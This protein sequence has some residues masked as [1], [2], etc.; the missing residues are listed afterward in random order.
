M[1]QRWLI[2]TLL[3]LLA[4]LLL[5]WL[6]LPG[7]G[8]VSG[9]VIE[10]PVAH[11]PESD[12]HG[13]GD[14]HGDDGHDDGQGDHEAHPPE[15]PPA[16]EPATDEHA[17]VEHPPHPP[18][19]ELEEP[20]HADRDLI[21]WL[22]EPLQPKLSAQRGAPAIPTGL[23]WPDDEVGA[24]MTQ[25]ID[26]EQ[27]ALG[28][29][30]AAWAEAEA[31][32]L[33]FAER[34]A[35]VEA[36]RAE[37]VQQ[38]EAAR[39]I[40]RAEAAAAPSAEA[41]FDPWHELALLMIEAR[42]VLGA[43]AADGIAASA[44][45]ERASSIV[46]GAPS[47]P[48]TPYARLFMMAALAY[49]DGDAYDPAGA[50]Q[51]AE[52][53]VSVPSDEHVRGEAFRILSGLPSDTPVTLDQLDTLMSA[54]PELPNALLFEAALA[55]GVGDLAIDETEAAREEALQACAVAS[56]VE[57]EQAVCHHLLDEVEQR[58]IR[59]ARSG[60]A[61]P[62]S[63][64]VELALLANRCADEHPLEVPGATGQLTWVQDPWTSADWSLSD[65]ELIGCFDAGLPDVHAPAEPI[66]L[67][68][69]LRNR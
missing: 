34:M 43:N 56:T 7:T 16:H 59:L 64:R 57:V 20:P 9:A 22:G 29:S 14:D 27:L 3:L 66:A 35:R 54:Q 26:A 41:T 17:E 51:Q 23:P 61:P 37:Y 40:L 44:V 6:A 65:S 10:R 55:N 63:W 32:G 11:A 24:A 69:H 31:Q 28:A 58:A 15:H 62:E 4:G 1:P 30:G 2:A 60:F 53:I 36:A 52:A 67:T 12:H 38:A 45:V 33:P 19:A 46:E 42:D 21:V 39:D 50:V 48:A 5:G 8:I 49:P 68:I 25:L 13:H 47:D 18:S